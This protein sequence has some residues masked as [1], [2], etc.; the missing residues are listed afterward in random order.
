MEAVFSKMGTPILQQSMR[1]AH[2]PVQPFGVSHTE[3]T[4]KFHPTRSSTAF[5][6]RALVQSIRRVIECKGGLQ[7][8]WNHS[9]Q[10]GVAG[11]VSRLAVTVYHSC[12]P[13]H[14]PDSCPGR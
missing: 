12:L 8:G 7:K 6:E 4:S 10:R 11:L 3:V 5:K 2:L 14:D 1:D 13:I 9:A